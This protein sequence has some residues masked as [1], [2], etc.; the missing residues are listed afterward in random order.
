[1]SFVTEKHIKAVKR[2]ISMSGDS[3]YRA[4]FVRQ[5]YDTIQV[6]ILIEDEFW[7]QSI[8]MI[9]K[10]WRERWNKFVDPRIC[11][12]VSVLSQPRA[13]EM[14]CEIISIQQIL[15]AEE[16]HTWS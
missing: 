10:L 1:M 2:I 6:V 11:Y 16:L 5:Y 14:C 15:T 8:N 7:R 9:I 3:Y 12:D 13:F 4:A